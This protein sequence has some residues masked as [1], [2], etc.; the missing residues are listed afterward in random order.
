MRGGRVQR[1]SDDLWGSISEHNL[2]GGAAITITLSMLPAPAEQ[3]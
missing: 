3:T 2:I 1:T